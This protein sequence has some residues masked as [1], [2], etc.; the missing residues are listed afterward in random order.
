MVCAG[1][2]LSRIGDL[3]VRVQTWE[4]VFRQFDIDNNNAIDGDELQPALEKLGYKLSEQLQDLLKRKY[5]AGL[6]FEHPMSS[7]LC[8]RLF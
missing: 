7:A 2:S 3:T 5:G 4:G 1:S 6:S 8:S